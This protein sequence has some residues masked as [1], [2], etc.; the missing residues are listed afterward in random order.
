MT[1]ATRPG[2]FHPTPDRLLIGLLAVEGLLWLS[3][4]FQWFRFNQHK[5]YTVLITLST[6]PLTA[7]VL[8]LWFAAAMAFR[9]RFQFTIRTLLVLTVAVAAPCS[10]MAVEMKRAREQRE[11]V[12]GIRESG[13]SL[14]YHWEGTGSM[15]KVEPVPL[16]LMQLFGDDFFSDVSGASIATDS[17][18]RYLVAFPHLRSLSLFRVSGFDQ[19]GRRQL[20]SAVTDAG[21]AFLGRLPQLRQLNLAGTKVTDAGLE[22]IRGLTQLEDLH[23]AGTQVT[24]EGVKKLQQA[25]PNC[26]IDWN[27]PTATEQRRETP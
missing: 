1:T 10:W 9:W 13:G 17:H 5:G 11:A 18:L 3:E 25:L 27:P 20:Q 14:R 19:D 23:L 26:Q 8:L 22:H 7:V 21:L 12:E 2:W 4:R 6:V 15:S 24:D 16:W